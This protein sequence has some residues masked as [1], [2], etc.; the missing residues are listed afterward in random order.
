MAKLHSKRVQTQSL[1]NLDSERYNFI[2]I[3]NVE[4]NLGAPVDSGYHLLVSD[5]SGIREWKR[6][7]YSFSTSS[8]NQTIITPVNLDAT[9]F[10]SVEYLVQCSNSTNYHTTKILAVNDGNN[11]YFTEYAT[12]TSN[13]LLGSFVVEL[14]SNNISLKVTP[15]NST[16]TTYKV[17]YSAVEM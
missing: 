15:F 11:V 8:T 10:R 13:G 2:N 5:S 16:L 4:P 1:S 6:V 3:Q 9:V 17:L 7:E 14:S 12:I